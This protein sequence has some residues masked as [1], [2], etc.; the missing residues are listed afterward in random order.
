MT[1]FS[2]LFETASKEYRAKEKAKMQP[3]QFVSSEKE[4]KFEWIGSKM[5]EVQE[6]LNKEKYKIPAYFKDL[7]LDL[8][9]DKIVLEDNDR[10]LTETFYELLQDRNEILYRQDIFKDLEHE[11]VY[12]SI[13]ELQGCL[14]QV[15]RI[16]EY[17]ANANHPIQYQK[18]MLDAMNLYYDGITGFIEKTAFILKSAGLTGLHSLF[19]AYA[20]SQTFL[21]LREKSRA[22]KEKIEAIRY[23]IT[24][25]P[26]RI[27]FHFGGNEHDFSLNIKNTFQPDK[28]DSNE[29]IF[30]REVTLTD[31]ELKFA[32]LL[33]KKEKALF[34]E[35]SD[36]TAA[37]TDFVDPVTARIHR[38]LK[39]Y[40]SCHNYIAGL[41]SKDFSFCYPAILEDRKIELNG[42]YNIAMASRSKSS[43]LIT[44]H[45]M[46]DESHTGAWITGANQGGKTTFARSLG[47]TAYFTL[48]GMPVPGS[49][50]RLPMFN[51][52]YTH[53]CAEEN[54]GTDNGKL[55]EELLHI[56]EMLTYAS[57]SNN[58]FILNE[59]FSSTTTSDAFDMSRLLVSRLSKLNSIVICVTHV[60][61][62]A[63]S[64]KDLLS[65]GTE[66][67]NQENNR[68]TYRIIPKPPELTAY[69]ADIAGKYRLTFHQITE[70]LNNAL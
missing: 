64:C 11:N 52:I 68:R 43:D 9:I 37:Y 48:L 66:T 41:K 24:L 63:A 2:L 1:Y 50:A 17:A 22:L 15:Y 34:T 61:N 5:V 23:H 45:L 13:L 33:Y 51:G 25:L 54:A 36:F 28:N 65:L 35:A 49:Y 53:F 3:Y 42:V 14:S 56:K 19:T 60:P 40:T 55:K 62:L 58:L 7:N 21:E 12:P 27:L 32:D 8:V 57:G 10:F 46:L 69:A 31:L 29:F 67:G 59:L 6:D 20:S 44:N 30:F 4:R 26:D 18:Y 47:Q 38:E 39:F 16:R 70:E